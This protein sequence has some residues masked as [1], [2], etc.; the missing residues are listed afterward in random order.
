MLTREEYQSYDALGLAEL[1][2]ECA[3][4]PREL[5]ETALA[6]A[7][8]VQPSI[9]CFVEIFGDRARAEI[10]SG[11]P[12]GP[13]TGVPFA[14][15]DLFMLYAGH[16]TRNGSRLCHESEAETS[17]ELF[18]RY[19]RAGFSIFAKTSTPEFG[20]SA[21]TEPATTGATRNPYDLSRS[22]GGS[23]GG[24]AAAVAAGV[25]PLAHA[26][27]SGG[28]IRIPASCCGL[29]GLKP[30]RGRMPMGPER[31]ESSAGLGT[32]HAVGV[33]VRDSA[34]LL[35][36]TSGSDAG[37][38][39]GIAAPARPWRLET[40]ADPA[41]MRIG[42]VLSPADGRPLDPECEK[43]CIEVGHLCEQLGHHV[44]VYTLPINFQSLRN[45]SGLFLASTTR[46][47]IDARAAALGRAASEWDMEPVT[48]A[49]YQKAA[50]VTGAQFVAAQAEFHRTGRTIARVHERFDL[51]LT[52][53]LAELPAPIRHLSMATDDFE[54]YLA[55][56]GRYAPL[57]SLSNI[58]GAPAMTLP[59][60]RSESGL[61]LGTQVIARFG[62]EASLFALAGQLERARPWRRDA[63]VMK[64]QLDSDFKT[65]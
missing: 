54:E 29:F 30:T 24:A 3:V 10:A 22:A 1:V 4:S 39:Y 56:A 32:A 59:L 25:L 44:D 49:I 31:G 58:T 8:E 46:A 55:R 19:R 43:A 63:G 11:L 57:S 33:S 65:H 60:H 28:S 36:A 64:P 45:A 5:L 14:L 20:L 9:N 47:L 18:E 12:D 51:L 13:F 50:A 6:I 15:K 48:W 21:T 7:A 17:S 41:P 53:M 23:S 52:P 35:D 37:A 38:P 16:S 42:I 40:E 34:A 26:S 61:P 2:R 27:D 62:D